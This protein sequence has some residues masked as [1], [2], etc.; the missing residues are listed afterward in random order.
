M[1]ETNTL[2]TNL[3]ARNTDFSQYGVMNMLNVKYMVYGPDRNHVI[4]NPSANG[5]AWFVQQVIPVAT[6]TEELRQVC[7]LD[8]RRSAVVNQSDHSVGRFSYDSAATIN[9]VSHNPNTLKYQ[10][11]S[12]VDGFAVFSEIFYPKGWVASIDGNPVDI[13]R[14]NYVLRALPVPAGDHTIEFN[15]EPKAYVVGNKVTMISS[16]LVLLIVLGCLG[17]EFKTWRE[18]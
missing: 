9:L 1:T 8:T 17:W 15:F 10:S 14:A 16:W 3:Q 2:I 18:S 11:Q 13:V 4:V 12:G 5:N 7:T 6:P